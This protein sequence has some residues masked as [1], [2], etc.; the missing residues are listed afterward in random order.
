MLPADLIGTASRA[1]RISLEELRCSRLTGSRTVFK[2]KQHEGTFNAAALSFERRNKFDC[3]H[4]REPKLHSYGSIVRIGLASFGL[5]CCFI[6]PASAKDWELRK[7]TMSSTCHVQPS[8]TRP[9][10]GELLVSEHD[11]RKAACQAAAALYD[12]DM[13][14]Q[15]KCYVYTPGAI[16]GCK[17][18]GITL[19]PKATKQS[20]PKSG[21][22]AAK[23]ASG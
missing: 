20:P 9:P 6:F 11:T 2:L 18:E 5:S 7:Q 3:A 12:D 8:T 23:S 15:S 13:A 19:P 10:L 4:Q 16:T 17:A 22:A 21:V 1:R 14:D